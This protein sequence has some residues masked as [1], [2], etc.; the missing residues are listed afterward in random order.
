MLRTTTE[1]D[2]ARTERLERR[3]RRGMPW[4]LPTWVPIV[5]ICGTFAIAAVV[6]MLVILGLPL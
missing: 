1:A 4:W 6:Y 3:H 2:I 5:T